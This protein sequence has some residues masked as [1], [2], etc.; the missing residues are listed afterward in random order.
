V[1]RLLLGVVVG[2][3]LASAGWF[4]WYRVTRSRPVE[5][6]IEHFGAADLVPT[7][8]RVNAAGNEVQAYGTFRT[9]SS[10]GWPGPQW[11][12]GGY[13]QGK[14]TVGVYSGVNSGNPPGAELGEATKTYSVGASV[15]TLTF[16]IATGF[17]TPP[18]VCA[19]RL[20]GVN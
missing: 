18:H 1:K 15:W 9:T 13:A 16:P 7:A 11:G 10:G 6:H 12:D 17:S 14:V 8:C 2:A 3:L 19:M 20:D 4:A 5:L